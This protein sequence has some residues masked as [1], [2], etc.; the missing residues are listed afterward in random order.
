MRRTLTIA[1]GTA[2]ALA[3]AAVAVAVVPAVVR[4][5]RSNRDVLD[6][7][8]RQVEDTLVHRRRARRGR[9]RTARYTGTVVSTN[10]VL[11]GSLTI[12]AKTTYNA[13]DKLGYVERLVPDQGRRQSR[14][15]HVLGHASRT[16]SSSAILTG[17]SRGQPRQGARQPER[18][19]SPVA[20]RTSPT[21]RSARAAPARSPSSPARSA[22]ATSRRPGRRSRSGIEV[23][24][25]SRR[26]AR[27]D[28]HGH[29]KDARGHARSTRTRDPGRL[30]GGTKESR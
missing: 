16:A 2:A 1:L 20:R 22:R 25:R 12:H 26:S 23:D 8:G 17:T 7:D 11:A 3:T 30:P 15:G 13:T 5:Q 28:D 6:D 24:E 21:A 14:E 18:R 27:G 19:R 29:R 4:C 9:S 10:A